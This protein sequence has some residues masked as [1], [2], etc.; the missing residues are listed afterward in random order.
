MAV[1]GSSSAIASRDNLE[2]VC[3]AGAVSGMPLTAPAVHTFSKL[4][5]L[6]IALDEPLTAI[7]TWISR[8]AL[9]ARAAR[10][11]AEDRLRHYALTEFSREHRGMLRALQA[12]L[13]SILL[14]PAV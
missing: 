12:K 4:S 13:E 1:S 9:F 7:V 3:T 11:S 2:N 5:R 6:A 14:F 8:P 10:R